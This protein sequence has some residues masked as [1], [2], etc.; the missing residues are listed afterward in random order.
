[1]RLSCSDDFARKSPS[2][3]RIGYDDCLRISG[4][5]DWKRNLR[6]EVVVTNAVSEKT[7]SLEYTG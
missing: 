6:P 1:L 3:N 2:L 7:V 5:L 4:M